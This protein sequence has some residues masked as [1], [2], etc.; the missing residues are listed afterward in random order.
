MLIFLCFTKTDMLEW[1][2]L[3]T[4]ELNRKQHVHRGEKSCSHFA[5]EAAGLQKLFKHPSCPWTPHLQLPVTE[6][7][8]YWL[9][10]SQG[11]YTWTGG[12]DL[13]DLSGEVNSNSKTGENRSTLRSEGFAWSDGDRARAEVPSAPRPQSTN[14]MRTQGRK[15]CGNSP[16][17]CATIKYCTL[18]WPQT[19]D[20]P[21]LKG[22]RLKLSSTVPGEQCS[23]QAEW[24][25]TKVKP[26]LSLQ[27]VIKHKS[28]TG[29]VHTAS[30]TA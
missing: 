24:S 23:I 9:D 3:K 26:K 4:E 8:G 16:A 29:T 12:L 14:R 13:S 5:L 25:R 21:L 30:A 15:L 18:R 7:K 17:R 20:K 6:T 1:D 22:V 11:F 19:E 2:N 27:K 10:S 28:T